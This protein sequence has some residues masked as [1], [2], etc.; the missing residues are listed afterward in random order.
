MIKKVVIIA[1]GPIELWPNLSEYQDDSSVAWVGVDRG[2]LNGLQAGIKFTFGVGDFDSVDEIEK[3]YIADQIGKLEPFPAEKDATDTELGLLKAVEAFPKAEEFLLIGVTGG[4]MDHF[5]ANLW[6]P[7]RDQ[8]QHFKSRIV[9]KDIQNSIRYFEPGTYT[10]VK[11]PDKKYLA[12]VCLTA[13]TGLSLY[14]AK[15]QLDKYQTALPMSWASNEF[16]GET[17]RFSFETGELC[18]IQSKDD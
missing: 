17:T 15:Y 5:L 12:F 16:I 8:L 6:L 9:L 1:G 3:K 11:E 7:F 14:D 13:V 2:C 18:V 10:I 4:R